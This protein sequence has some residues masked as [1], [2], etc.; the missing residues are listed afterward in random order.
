MLTWLLV[1]FFRDDEFYELHM[2]AKYRPTCKVNF[3]S[4]I[5]QQDLELKDLSPE[6]EIEEIAFQEFVMKQHM[7]NNDDQRF[8][9]VPYILIQLTLTFFCFGILKSRRHLS[10]KKWQLPAHFA[11]CFIPTSFG[12]AFIVAFD[13]LSWTIIL[14]TLLLVINYFT[15]IFLTKDIYNASH[16]KPANH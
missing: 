9:Y 15:L 4:P 6:K 16:C 3:Y 8:W 7:Q 2:F 12:L 11:I 10:Y 5:G 13:N 14:A 1:G